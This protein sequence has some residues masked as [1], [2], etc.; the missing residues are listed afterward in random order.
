MLQ[1]RNVFIVTSW[2]FPYVLLSYWLHFLTFS[3]FHFFFFFFW[4]AVV[5]RVNYF[6]D[7]KFWDVHL[8]DLTEFC[9]TWKMVGGKGWVLFLLHVDNVL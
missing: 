7:G 3:L 4:S 5:S 2:F 9:S 1:F 6:A 8:G